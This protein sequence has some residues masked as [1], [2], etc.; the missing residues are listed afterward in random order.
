MQFTNHIR[1]E[2][3][4]TDTPENTIA[5]IRAGF[6]Q[7]GYAIRYLP[8]Q[9]A[10]HIHW[11]FIAI[12]ALN[13]QCQGKGLTPQLAKASAHAELAERFSGG[14]F[15][16]AF[17]EQVR[18]NLPALYGP[19]V[20]RFLNY[21]WLD[22]YVNCHQDELSEEHL[23]IEALLRGQ[24]HLSSADL[25]GIKNSQMARHW[26]DGYSVLEDRCLKVP[27]N[28][29][30]YIN[31]SN[32]MAAGNTLEE[33]LV[34]AACEVF[35]RHTQIQIIGPEARVPTIDRS[36]L[37]NER[38]KAMIAFYENENVEIVLKDLSMEGRFPSIGVLF[39]NHNL[40][41]GRLEHK[42]LVPGVSFNMD[43][44]L[45]RCLTEIMQ[46]RNT[47]K[48]ATP[49]LDRPVAH[50]ARVENLYLLFKC[51][52][53]RKDISFLEK[54]DTAAYQAFRSEDL[55]AEIEAIKAIC[56]TL[57]TDFIVLNLTHPVLNFPVVRVVLPGV[58]D[59]LPFVYRDILTSAETS[60]QST[61]RGVRYKAAMDSF[62]V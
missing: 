24:G 9:V 61:W 51:C 57:E 48:A 60:P 44:A 5:K 42:I 21:Q 20:N 49:E 17:E 53:S 23:S 59:F 16:Q 55:F 31:A 39:I 4:K 7:L 13:L 33:A 14:L 41:P 2:F 35:E 27:L 37:P 15:Y 6:E 52:I 56:R 3:G 30:T 43:E 18:F 10:D 38:L 46:G 47:L 19:E 54:G 58:S 8:F 25:A 28:F 26:V 22:G 45:S 50:R 34:Q 29:V 1:N 36:T 62:F 32:G 11:S 12:D 40:R